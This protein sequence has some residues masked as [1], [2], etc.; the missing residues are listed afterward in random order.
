VLRPIFYHSYAKVLVRSI[1]SVVGCYL[2]RMA[3]SDV[4]EANRVLE[5]G[6]VVVAARFVVQWR[7]GN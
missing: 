2:A 7:V 5:V 6:F 3:R 1:R 4:K